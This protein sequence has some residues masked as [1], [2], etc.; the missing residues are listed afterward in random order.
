MFH[1]SVFL[2]KEG[3]RS[4]RLLRTGGGSQNQTTETVFTLS[5]SLCI[6]LRINC[7]YLYSNT[8]VFKYICIST[9]ICISLCICIWIGKYCPTGQSGYLKACFT[10]SAMP[11]CLFHHCHP[12]HPRQAHRRNHHHHDQ[13][14][15]FTVEFCHQFCKSAFSTLLPVISK[16]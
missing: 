10:S 16:Q 3:H 14:H 15:Q 11:R 12:R 2:Y 4:T 9:C 7:L 5:L 8:F 6:C 1:H 13:H